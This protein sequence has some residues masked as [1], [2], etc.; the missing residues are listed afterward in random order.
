MDHNADSHRQEFTGKANL[1]L[2]DVVMPEKK[3]ISNAIQ[4]QLLGTFA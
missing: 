3:I 2:A 4:E 1:V